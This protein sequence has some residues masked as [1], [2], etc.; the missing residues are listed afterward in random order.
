MM[1]QCAV[2]IILCVGA[3]SQTQKWQALSVFDSDCKELL[4]FPVLNYAACY[5]T[6]LLFEAKQIEECTEVCAIYYDS[7]AVMKT[8]YDHFQKVK[9]PK[10][11]H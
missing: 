5:G 4:V 1:K 6:P 11:Y 3:L 10:W 7:Y 9:I 8:C 2:F